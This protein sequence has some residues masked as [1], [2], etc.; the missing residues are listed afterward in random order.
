L[1]PEEFNAVAGA[2]ETSLVVCAADRMAAN[3]KQIRRNEQ[4]N[5]NE[6]KN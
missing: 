5:N 2:D 4:Q 1:K 6:D 3:C